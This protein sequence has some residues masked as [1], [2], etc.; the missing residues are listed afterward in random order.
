MTNAIISDI[1]GKTTRLDYS[2]KVSVYARGH[3]VHLDFDTEM[4][5][6]LRKLLML[7]RQNGCQ[8]Y[9]LTKDEA[10]SKWVRIEKDVSIPKSKGKPA[11]N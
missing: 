7:A 9:A 6:E 5:D 11:D 3:K 10:T 2:Y 1:T 4:V 8:W